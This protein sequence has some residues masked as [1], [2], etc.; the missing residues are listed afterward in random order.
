MIQQ[1]CNVQ[2]NAVKGSGLVP[3]GATCIYTVWPGLTR[4]T[5]RAVWVCQSTHCCHVHR[6]PPQ[7]HSRLG[8]LL[9][10]ASTA[11]TGHPLWAAQVP[12][13]IFLICLMC[14]QHCI[15]SQAMNA[16][17]QHQRS[18]TQHTARTI[19]CCTD[20]TGLIIGWHT[21]AEL[22]SAHLVCLMAAMV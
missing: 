8:R 21:H 18:A 4:P 11:S 14:Q 1:R 15:K 20:S 13:C 2:A 5:T 6:L 16:K 19:T 12:C 22:L 7:S 3:I 10:H 17:L 9:E